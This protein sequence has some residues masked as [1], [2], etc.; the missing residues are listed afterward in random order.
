V[1]DPATATASALSHESAQRLTAI[2][3]GYRAGDGD[4]A[5]TPRQILT[6][7]PGR[8]R[9]MFDGMPAAA[10]A[11]DHGVANLIRNGQHRSYAKLAALITRLP[12]IDHLLTVNPS[13]QRPSSSPCEGH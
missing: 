3:A 13:N 12:T 9:A 2:A 11:G 4:G 8:I 5:F 1:P 7:V 10:A 6:A